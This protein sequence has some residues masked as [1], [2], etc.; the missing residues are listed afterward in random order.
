MNVEDVADEGI[1][2]PTADKGMMALIFERQ[3]ELMTR[4]EVIEHQNGLLQTADIPVSLHDR[5][6]QARL[7]DMAWRV[8]EEL[9]EAAEALLEHGDVPTHFLEEV[10]DA[11]HFLVEFTIL[12]DMNPF[13]HSPSSL[14]TMF[15][16]SAE[17]VKV[18][19]PFH[20]DILRKTYFVI[21]YLGLSCNCLKNKPWKQ[22]HQLTDIEKF[23]S[24]VTDAWIAF[25]DLC[26]LAGFTSDSLFRMYF[27]KSEVNK[28]RQRSAY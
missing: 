22:T 17:R 9:T 26:Y 6:G 23:Q 14:Q 19:P 8:T 20:D 4:Y 10:S 13:I 27:K 15:N 5:F 2:T 7:K 28:F 21:H 16:L 25:I 12:A 24:R 1:P 11:M 18:H 3:R